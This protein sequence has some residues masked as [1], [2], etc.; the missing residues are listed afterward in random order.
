MKTLIIYG[1]GG[2][3]KICSDIAV[4]MKRWDNIVF[5]DDYKNSNPNLIHYTEKQIGDY[6]SKDTDFFVAIGDNN[7][8]KSKNELLVSLNARIATLIDPSSTI[9]TNVKIGTGTVIMPNTVI[10]HGVSI[11]DGVIINTSSIIEHECAIS[12]FVHVSPGAVLCGSVIVGELS[13][14]GANSTIINNLC[15]TKC[16]AVGAGAVVVS[17]II[18]S[19]IYIG[20][21]ARKIQK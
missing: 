12:D 16:V 21:P 14:I 13:W 6:V 2:H 7:I 3:G 5:Y 1:A 9:G 4:R 8:R 10:N 18:D 20:V 17:N 11:G 15:I 19:G